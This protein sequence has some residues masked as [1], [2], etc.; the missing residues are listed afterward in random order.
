MASDPLES[1]LALYETRNTAKFSFVDVEQP[2]VQQIW[3]K[4][5][6]LRLA[7]RRDGNSED[8]L[9]NILYPLYRVRNNIAELPH[10]FDSP[11][12]GIEEVVK[13]ATAAIMGKSEMS[14]VHR[15]ASNVL[16]LLEAILDLE[17]PISGILQKVVSPKSLIVVKDHHKVAELNHY[18]SEHFKSANEIIAV[19]SLSKVSPA[20]HIVYLGSPMRLA[21]NFGGGLD[22]R[23]LLDP[24]ARLNT[25]IMYS[26]SKI[27]KVDGLI[28]GS[29]IA[30]SLS[31]YSKFIT[32][33]KADDGD[34]ITDWDLIGAQMKRPRDSAELHEKAR[35]IGL[36]GNHY[37]WAEST[38]TS[39]CRVLTV[40]SK[41]SLDLETMPLS[42]LAP[43]HY[44][45]E[46]TTSSSGSMIDQ[47][48]DS[49]GAA[50]L[51]KS[52]LAFKELLRKQASISGGFTKFERTLKTVAKVTTTNIR[53][54]AYDP[55]S[56]GP[57]NEIDFMK[58]M[59][60]LGESEQAEQ[61]WKDF[62]EIRRLHLKAGMEIL[63]RLREALMA[64]DVIPQ[65]TKGGFVLVTVPSC[66]T[67][68]AFRVEHV[69]E[70]VIDIPVSWIDVIQKEDGAF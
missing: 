10:R 18:A 51:R 19:R 33:L 26:F 14:E 49:L 29:N 30:P 22:T 7:I 11:V 23:F 20:E 17:N 27:P 47:L 3:S 60:H 21:S 12:I 43:D 28:E 32:G 48:A 66:G 13:S 59:N 31:G 52:Q 34:G 5:N 4:V 62:K 46:R 16:K 65:L 40:D 57:Q 42:E 39:R 55:R 45:V 53:H 25:F 63:A 58:I 2:L 68:G 37:V 50:K 15:T 35:F 56:I 67:L 64:Q 70:E 36:A 38:S 61:M 69:S 41:G 54:W 24:R 1:A 9:N 6:S 44:I 8:D